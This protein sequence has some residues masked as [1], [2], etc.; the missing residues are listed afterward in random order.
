VTKLT[1]LRTTL[2]LGSSH[3]GFASHHARSRGRDALWAR[4]QFIYLTGR[5]G[6]LSELTAE[7]ARCR[8]VPPGKA[9]TLRANR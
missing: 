6:S 1:R 8:R 3:V 7:G 4:S 2:L 5:H 9:S